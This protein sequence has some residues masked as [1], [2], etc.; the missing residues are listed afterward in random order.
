ME[1]FHAALDTA[2]N[3]CGMSA[4]LLTSLSKICRPSPASMAALCRNQVCQVKA[5][6]SELGQHEQQYRHTMTPGL[7]LAQLR[8]S[9]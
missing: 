1:G 5:R 8:L 6:S 3:P 2:A 9:R 7:G 4:R